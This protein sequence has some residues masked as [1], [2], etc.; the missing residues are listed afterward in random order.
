MLRV[1]LTGNVGAGKTALSRLFEAWGARVVDADVLAREAV[2][3]GSPALAKIREIW[4][5]Q[6]IGEGGGLDR[7]AMRRL[8]FADPGARR[9]LELILHPAILGRTLQLMSEAEAAG[10]EVFIAVVPLLYEAGFS[11]EFDMVV[12]ID[13]P[14]QQRIARMLPTRDLDEEEARR[15]A[16]AQMPAEKKRELADLVLENDSDMETLE[17]RAREAWEQIKRRAASQ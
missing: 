6:V 9:D 8:A 4:G 15:I 14:L 10:V 5:E 7:R 16:A 11:G 2:K 12:L 17:R 13:A 3:L 1:A